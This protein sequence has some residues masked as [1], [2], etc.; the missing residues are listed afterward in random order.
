MAHVRLI[1][2]VLL[3]VSTCHAVLAQATTGTARPA[4]PPPSLRPTDAALDPSGSAVPTTNTVVP[5]DSLRITSDTIVLTSRRGDGP[6]EFFFHWWTEAEPSHVP[7]AIAVDVAHNVYLLIEE[8][9]AATEVIKYASDGR[10]VDTLPLLGALT[11]HS[12][13]VDGA[14]NLWI[15]ITYYGTGALGT[16]GV[17][18]REYSAKGAVLQDLP[19]VFHDDLLRVDILQDGTPQSLTVVTSRLLANQ[20]S[21]FNRDGMPIAR[22]DNPQL[23]ATAKAEV[24]NRIAVESSKL[25]SAAEYLGT[26]KHRISMGLEPI[27]EVIRTTIGADGNAYYVVYHV[28]V[29]KDVADLDSLTVR[30]LTFEAAGGPA[31]QQTKRNPASPVTV[32]SGALPTTK[33]R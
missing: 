15:P 22:D 10:Y 13:N 16:S 19:A 28:P 29:G 25:R 33:T 27:Y 12:M 9:D 18:V 20:S 30:K 11:V 17:R 32:R 6:G 5:S 3:C 1:C 7:N 23:V 21:T 8:R 4:S 2:F 14:G 31:A 24:E 26:P